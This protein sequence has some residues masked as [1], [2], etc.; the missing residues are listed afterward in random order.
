MENSRGERVT[1]VGRE[2]QAIIQRRNQRSGLAEAGLN[3]VVALDAKRA[4][5]DAVPASYDGLVVQLKSETDAR[6]EVV[7][8]PCEQRVGL[9]VNTRIGQAA[10][11]VE[12][13]DRNFG[14]GVFRIIRTDL[15]I[16]R[17]RTGE[18]ESPDAAVES[19]AG[20][21]FPFPSQAQV[22]SQSRGDLPIVLEVKRPDS[23]LLGEGRILIYAAAR[24]NAQQ[25]R[26]QA[27]THGSGRGIVEGTARIGGIEDKRPGGRVVR[28][29]LEC[30][31]LPAV[32]P[33]FHHVGRRGGR[34]RFLPLNGSG[35]GTATS[36]RRPLVSGDADRRER[37]NSRVDRS[38]IR[39][40]EPERE[41]IESDTLRN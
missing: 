1:E 4:E 10:H 32:T 22:Q 11:Q 27:L 29:K 8:I 19:L 3:Y 28:L 41:R 12:V 37:Q 16:Q 31:E 23:R 2:R 30:P 35:A 38:D 17:I 15:R 9:P 6:H 40:G 7:P 21:S 33:E 20:R 18:I 36:C 34:S 24:G 5:I 26:G 39:L 25:E 14:D 13:A